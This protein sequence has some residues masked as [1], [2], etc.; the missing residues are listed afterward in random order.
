MTSEPNNA[1]GAS[2][3]MAAT[4][5]FAEVPTPEQ[6]P[7]PPLRLRRVRLESVG[8]DGARFDPLDLDFATRDG[9]AARVL[10]SLTN[11]G[12][13]STWI[14]LVSSL[15]V[16]AARAQIAG[17][18]L[19]DYV[20]T[21]D[22]SHI[23]C[24]WED[25]TTGTRTVTGT[26]MEWKDGRRQPGDKQRSTTNMHRAWYLFRTG[27]DLPALDDLPFVI[28][29]RRA[30]FERFC[31]AAGDLISREPRAQWAI[32]RTQLDWTSTLE[33]R[34]SID[35]VLFGYQMRMN[36][37]EAGAEKLL[38]TFDSADNVVRFFVAALND[39]REIAD[40]TA[41]LKPYAE[42]AAQRTTL[43]ALA[44]FGEHLSPRIELI[45]LRKATADDAAAGLL[46]AGVAGGELCTALA[47]RIEFDQATLRQLTDEAAH[48]A[49]ELAA[50]R[51][52]VGQI[53]DI[54]LQLQLE[55]ARTR[56]AQAF[57]AESDATDRAS[58]TVFEAAAW[59]AV[60]IILEIELAQQELT[61]A[62]IAYEAADSDLTPLRDQVK[63][64]AALLA[65]RLEALIAE[66]ESAAETADADAEE[67]GRAQQAATA[68]QLSAEQDRTKAEEQLKSMIEAAR[69]AEQAQTAA[70]EAGWLEPGE[71]PEACLLRWTQAMR[72][73][74]DTV[75]RQESAADE[76]EAEFD[77]AAA[78]LTVLDPE[79]TRL[80]SAALQA[81]NRLTAFDSELARLAESNS[82]TTLLGGAPSDVA[83]AQ[84]VIEL[85]AQATAAAD[86][87]AHKHEQLAATARSELAHIDE[88]GTSPTGPDVI[89]VL[90]TLLEARF[91]AVSGLEWIERNI[92][93]PSDRPSYIEA[94]PDVAGGVIVSDP[95]RFDQ[96]ISSLAAAALNLRTPITVT[97][98]PP[99]TQQHDAPPAA[100]HH[101]VLPHRATWD[102]EWAAE[103]REAL[104]RTAQDEGQAAAGALA[105][106]RS[107]RDAAAAC[108]AFTARWPDTSRTDL[109]EEAALAESAVSEADDRHK[110]LTAAQETHRS[111]ARRARTDAA[112]ARE[113]GRRA[114]RH[115]AHAT[116]LAEI[117]SRA[118]ALEATNPAAAAAHADALKRISDAKTEFTSAAARIQS[119]LNTAAGIRASR[120]TWQQERDEIDAEHPAP[121]P[122][123]NLNVVKA[124]WRSLRDELST[125][126]QGL[127]QAEF[128]RRAQRNH[129]DALAK[130]HRFTGNV[131]KRGAELSATVVASSR[132]SL[133]NA[134]QQAKADAR[135]AES[136][137]LRAE[138]A[139]ERAE[140]AV[141]TATPP[142]GDRINHFDLA[143]AP[144]WQPADPSLI[145]A[146][147]DELETYNEQVRAKRDT[148]EQ[149]EHDAVEL[150][151]AIAG[152][153]TG[154][155]DTMNMCPAEPVPTSRRFE[156]GKE[157]AREQ[158]HGLMNSL[159]EAEGVE[160]RASGELR[161][162][163]TAVRSAS[164]DPRWRE[165]DAPAAVRIRSLPDSDLVA[166]AE[167][168]GRR[169]RAMGISAAADL[170]KIDEH[171]TILRDNLV[172]LCREQRRLLREVSRASKLP[173]GLGE[174]SEQ[175]AIKIR[176][177]DAPDD[178]SAVRL[179]KR[180]DDWTEELVANPKRAASAEV[181]T[182]WLADAVRDSVIDRTRAGAWSI[183][184][185]KPRVD[186]KAV[187]CSPERIPREFSGGQV[188]TLAVL[189]YCALS[190]VRSAHR[191][192]G[193]RP[194]GALIL[195]N[196]FGAASNETLIAMQHQLAARTGLQLICATGLNDPAVDAAFTGLGS[197]I[198]KLRNDGDTRR[199]LSFLRLRTRIIDGLHLHDLLTAGRD[200]ASP[201]NWVDATGYEIRR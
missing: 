46:R 5:L 154:F 44:G 103:T 29:G 159:R 1:V 193:A 4:G 141:R 39:D 167:T 134:Q 197:V 79:L 195:D 55:L 11:T 114:E 86:G 138:H 2:L 47:N 124:A 30:T 6:L 42:L 165:L 3:R 37:S 182:R 60:D 139:R 72:Q 85:A 10:L 177:E 50:A 198:M 100:L 101:I 18:V 84:R 28:E 82:I 116:A 190:G 199:N 104:E 102:R 122:G 113:A 110:E 171:R 76:H 56:L 174:L 136:A 96:A 77:A 89:A 49:A 123:G 192:G 172:S 145:P 71:G 54:R 61:S 156:G 15:I 9:A 144:R 93:D 196:P 201:R 58:R 59:E 70:I 99:S 14:T 112:Q 186:G 32:T 94:R 108:Q 176:F 117:V 146:L 137:R 21:G 189:V 75:Q 106:A 98:P 169:V 87:R 92:T 25:T 34:T 66:A 81:A 188:L 13:K 64:A 152:D 179:A 184:I 33:K 52:E 125:A 40:F 132:E 74:A 83:A 67:G 142:S 45:G 173:R 68:S 65:G 200:T 105:S 43:Q 12:G 127:V 69:A 129:A 38:A 17:K 168:L 128:L 143:N 133:N 119:A 48:A 36:D 149:Q 31:A 41:K 191:P 161:D 24:E 57:A 73:A 107:H 111:A 22:T 162:A 95:A 115:T 109:A 163:I 185:L 80:R 183:E 166:E 170:A 20:L 16:P 151:D 62:R 135:N 121:D 181:R 51:R 88:T 160:R 97:T 155:G 180:I 8:P 194:P 164:T 148:A 19:G 175:P 187:Y 53:S 78:T 23:V 91:G 26:V 118:R 130:R 7:V 131:L 157:T 27:P 140:D 150:R 147:L 120:T 35:P 178:E 90:R 63:Q 158:M 153:I 126:E